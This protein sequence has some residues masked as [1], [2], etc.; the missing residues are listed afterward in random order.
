MS[1]GQVGYGQVG[2]ETPQKR[3]AEPATVLI[4]VTKR[5]LESE[6]EQDS[7]LSQYA[8]VV[9]DS[10]LDST[11][12]GDRELKQRLAAALRARS[13]LRLVLC[14]DPEQGDIIRCMR[15]ITFESVQAGPEHLRSIPP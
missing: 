8:M 13:G 6:L 11:T 3:K 1:T 2:Y 9:I 15:I 7:S 14:T 12:D 10:S 4:F 5:Q